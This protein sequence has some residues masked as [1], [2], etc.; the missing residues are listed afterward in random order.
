M[1]LLVVSAFVDRLTQLESLAETAWA[2]GADAFEIRMDTWEDAPEAL[3]RYLADHP[4][5]RWI[6]TCRSEAE[7]GHFAGDLPQR[8]SRLIAVARGTGAY[9]DFEAKDWERSSNIR[10]KITL[11]ATKTSCR[12]DRSRGRGNPKT[13]S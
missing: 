8:V 12:R 9:V 7:G 6:V 13:S 4:E 5:R 10:Q 2:R 1:T 11:A 3:H